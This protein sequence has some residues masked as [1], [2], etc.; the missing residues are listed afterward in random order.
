MVFLAAENENRQLG[1]LLQ[2]DF[3][4]VHENILLSIRKKS[5][6]ENF[7]KRVLRPSS[8]YVM[9][10]RI[11]SSRALSRTRFTF[12]FSGIVKPQF[13]FYGKVGFSSQ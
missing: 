9:V 5:T 8:L 3:G 10:R 2:A 13:P 12:F 11:F 6:P 7:V 4:R 1:D